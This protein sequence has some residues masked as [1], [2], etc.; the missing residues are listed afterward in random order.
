MTTKIDFDRL[1]PQDKRIATFTMVAD[2]C[3]QHLDETVQAVH[4]NEAPLSHLVHQNLM[5][6]WT[7]AEPPA[8][9]ACM[10][11][12]RTF[13]GPEEVYHQTVPE[14][15]AFTMSRPPWAHTACLLQVVEEVWGDFK[16]IV[17]RLT[18]D[19]VEKLKAGKP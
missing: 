8:G 9:M 6:A 19:L 11:C 7:L 4:G 10:F 15:T 13:S 14:L 18:E 16:F 5:A 3:R 12:R 1:S 17:S 2:L